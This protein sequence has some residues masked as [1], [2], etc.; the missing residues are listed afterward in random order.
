M[1]SKL[2]FLLC[3]KSY[4]KFKKEML[5]PEISSRSIIS[6]LEFISPELILVH[7]SYVTKI[8]HS[9]GG[10]KD[11]DL[12]IVSIKIPFWSIDDLHKEITQ[13]LEPISKSAKFDISLTTPTG[14]MAHINGKTALGLSLLQGFTV[15][16]NSTYGGR[17]NATQ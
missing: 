5:P 17:V 16:Y 3:M 2:D 15:L 7:G 13:R 10:E 1:D 12:V 8:R 11:I 4:E 14:L 9:I 6:A